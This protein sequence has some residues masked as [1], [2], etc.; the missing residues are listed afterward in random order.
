MNNDVLHRMRYWMAA[1]LT[2]TRQL[3]GRNTLALTLTVAGAW[4][5]GKETLT[6]GTLPM[7][8]RRV[9]VMFFRV[10]AALDNQSACRPIFSICQSG[11]CSIYCQRELPQV[12]REDRDRPGRFFDVVFTESN[13]IGL[14]RPDLLFS[15]TRNYDRLIIEVVVTHAPERGTLETYKD[16]EFTTGILRPTHSDI[17]HA[18]VSGIHLSSILDYPKHQ[19]IEWKRPAPPRNNNRPLLPISEEEFER[20]LQPCR[21]VD[22]NKG[23]AEGEFFWCTTHSSRTTQAARCSRRIMPYERIEWAFRYCLIMV[24]K[25]CGKLGIRHHC[26]RV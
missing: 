21:F 24:I 1:W 10:L 7:L 18:W 14:R 20:R 15:T 6:S 8:L 17:D 16:I 12:P 4:C 19:C 2:S 23:K 13:V 22:D 11:R 9:S 5:H 26:E 3:K 25:P